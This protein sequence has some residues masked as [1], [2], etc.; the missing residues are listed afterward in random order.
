MFKPP[1]I[2][3]NGNK[4][5]IIDR[6]R[7][8]LHIVQAPIYAQ[9]FMVILLLILFFILYHTEIRLSSGNLL[10]LKFFYF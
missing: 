4:T 2:K 5:N 7:Y 8:L 9:Y 10:F 1:F 3:T 6:L